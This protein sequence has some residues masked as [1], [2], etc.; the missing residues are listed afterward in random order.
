[1]PFCSQP[2]P[3]FFFEEGGGGTHTTIKGRQTKKPRIDHLFF[4]QIDD[5]LESGKT[6]SK[7]LQELKAKAGE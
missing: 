5:F 2:L 6:V 1:L 3:T 4:L 7:R